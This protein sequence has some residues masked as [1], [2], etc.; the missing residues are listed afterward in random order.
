[1]KVYTCYTESHIQLHEMLKSSLEKTNPDLELVSD[2][3]PQECVTGNFMES[4][5]NLTMNKKMDQII[6]SIDTG[7]IF[8]HSDADVYFFK[9]VKDKLLEEL[10]D[11]DIAFQDD[12]FSGLCC[13][14]FIARPSHNLKNL[15]TDV[16]YNI[17]RYGNDQNA[18]NMVIKNHPIKYKMLSRTFFTYGHVGRGIWNNDHFEVDPNIHVAHA[19]WTVGVQ[20][21]INLIN[22]MREKIE[23]L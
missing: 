18:L 15:W 6:N 12:S 14:F 4:G 22:F 7:E 21:K 17:D 9:P 23:N 19:N 3:L 5:W 1:M 10:G 2:L 16:K 20:N 8:I 13:G 11:F